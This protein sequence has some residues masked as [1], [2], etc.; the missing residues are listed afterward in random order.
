LILIMNACPFMKSFVH[1]DRSH[2]EA[3]VT[4]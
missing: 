3:S 4:R 1:R 2:H